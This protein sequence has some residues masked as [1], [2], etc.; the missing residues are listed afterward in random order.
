VPI[1]R[2]QLSTKTSHKDE[3]TTRVA[4]IVKMASNLDIALMEATRGFVLTTQLGYLLPRLRLEEKQLKL[5]VDLFADVLQSL[6][7]AISIL[8]PSRDTI[9]SSNSQRSGEERRQKPR[10]LSVF[11]NSLS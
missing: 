3:K 7:E 4:E 5:A 11:I 6:K 2:G 8:N 1:N 10:Y 9:T